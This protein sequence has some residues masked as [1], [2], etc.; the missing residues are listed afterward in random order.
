MKFYKGGMT[1]KDFF[2]YLIRVPFYLFFY[3]ALLERSVRC[4][5]MNTFGISFENLFFA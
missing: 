4:Q 3:Y 2:I 5:F 1:M